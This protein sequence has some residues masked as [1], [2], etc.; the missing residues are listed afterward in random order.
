[1]L[2]P[3]EFFCIVHELIIYLLEDIYNTACQ[4]GSPPHYFLLGDIILLP[5]KGDQLSLDHKRPI[6][7]LNLVY[8]ILAKF[9]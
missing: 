7:L 4:D 6:T 8:K 1:M 5:K 9:W 3:V 2:G